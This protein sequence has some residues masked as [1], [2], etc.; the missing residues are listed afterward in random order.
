MLVSFLKISSKQ[1]DLFED[2]NNKKRSTSGNIHLQA[3]FI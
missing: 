2:N 1:D 3:N